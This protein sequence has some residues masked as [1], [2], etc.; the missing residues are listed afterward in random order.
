MNTFTPMVTEE[1]SRSTKRAGIYLESESSKKQKIGEDV[2]A[3]EE[4]EEREE[5][6]T[7][8]KLQ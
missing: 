6:L 7:D 1:A 8:E 2:S 5:E 4:E 3:T